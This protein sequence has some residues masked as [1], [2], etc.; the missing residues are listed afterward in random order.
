MESIGLKL[1]QLQLRLKFNRHFGI[2]C[3][4]VKQIGEMRR[5]LWAAEPST[6]PL[7]KPA[8]AGYQSDDLYV[9]G[10]LALNLYRVIE[11]RGPAAPLEKHERDGSG[12]RRAEN[13]VAGR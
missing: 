6:C 13:C 11:A 1:E 12:H 8:M 4:G 7:A 5:S 3:K 2:V 10:P 9:A